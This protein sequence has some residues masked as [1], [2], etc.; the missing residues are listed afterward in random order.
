MRLRTFRSSSFFLP[1][2]H[3]FYYWFVAEVLMVKYLFVIFCLCVI[4][5]LNLGHQL[6][7]GE[8]CGDGRGGFARY[9]NANN[10]KQ[11]GSW[12][13]NLFPQMTFRLI[14]LYMGSPLSRI[15]AI[16]YDHMFPRFP[17]PGYWPVSLDYIIHPVVT[18]DYYSL[19]V[20][21]CCIRKRENDWKV[22][23]IVDR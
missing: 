2:S 16:I 7:K 20:G 1:F 4:M 21:G 15:Y 12:P 10:G 11:N 5:F 19:G 13:P 22:R 3:Q 9:T 6:T 8:T 17:R 23:S 14:S 18:L